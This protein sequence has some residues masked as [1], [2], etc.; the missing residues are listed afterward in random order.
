M[1]KEPYTASTS[2]IV[3]V[4]LTGNMRHFCIRNQL[5]S[6]ARGVVF[7]AVS[8]TLAGDMVIVYSQKPD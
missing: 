8:L 7:S 4:V 2:P 1:H 3:P 6:G 5:M